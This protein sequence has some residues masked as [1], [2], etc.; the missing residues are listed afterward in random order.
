MRPERCFVPLGVQ[1][2]Q[3]LRTSHTTGAFLHNDDTLFNSETLF[4]LFTQVRLS[5]YYRY[6]LF[7]HFHV[8]HALIYGVIKTLWKFLLRT[9]KEAGIAGAIASHIIIPSDVQKIMTERV[10]TS[11]FK[12]TGS[13]S[14]KVPDVVR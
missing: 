13:V 12:A 5:A 6:H 1:D 2:F 7:W 3:A 10:R 8:A 14:G 9:P 11:V 4:K